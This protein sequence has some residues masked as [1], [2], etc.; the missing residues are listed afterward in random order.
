MDALTI[1]VLA[2]K[3]LRGG[4]KECARQQEL[5]Y[6]FWAERDGVV[7]F[8][9][10]YRPIWRR[11]TDGV[12]R[13]L[14]DRDEWI[15]FTDK[16]WFYSDIHTEPKKIT[17]ALAGMYLLGFPIPDALYSD[18]DSYR[19]DSTAIDIVNEAL[20]VWADHVITIKQLT[21]P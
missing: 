1:E 20:R 12:W 17:R 8:N 5:A 11:K 2:C 15:D 7:L 10:R 18:L 16:Q 14:L 19:V 4:L 3:Y 9:R 6:G 21:H 13:R